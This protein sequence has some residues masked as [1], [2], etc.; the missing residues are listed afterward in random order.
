MQ[1]ANNWKYCNGAKRLES[2]NLEA[3]LMHNLPVPAKQR[4]IPNNLF[5]IYGLIL[6]NK[7]IKDISNYYF[8]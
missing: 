8:K 5:M 2:S 4:N 7:W 1:T 3:A 6:F